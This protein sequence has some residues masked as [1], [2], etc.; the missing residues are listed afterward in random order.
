M[1]KLFLKNNLH[2]II[3]YGNIG[4][5]CLKGKIQN[6]EIKKMRN[7]KDSWFTVC[8]GRLLVGSFARFR[9]NHKRRG[10]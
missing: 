5:P 9:R 2:F 4:Q 10:T 8:Y 1:L 6:M 7:F 3:D